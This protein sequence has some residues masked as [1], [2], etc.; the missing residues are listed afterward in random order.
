MI[1]LHDARVEAAARAAYLSQRKEMGLPD[2]WDALAPEYQAIYVRAQSAALAAADAAVIRCDYCG[3]DLPSVRHKAHVPTTPSIQR[4]GFDADKVVCPEC[5][6]RAVRAKGAS[7][8]VEKV[9]QAIYAN[10]RATVAFTKSL[11]GPEAD[12]EDFDYY[13]KHVEAALDA[14]MP[15]V[16]MIAAALHGDECPDDPDEGESCSCD[17]NHYM[18]QGEI[19]HALL[20]GGDER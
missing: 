10:T 17:G 5:V 19:V 15:T 18:R 14:A 9:A 8:T 7:V 2:N 12:H 20:R 4:L 13:R 11:L 16:E 3:D 1:D 6:I